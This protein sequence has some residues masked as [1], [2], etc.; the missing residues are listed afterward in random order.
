MGIYVPEKIQYEMIGGM[1]E[2]VRTFRR[3]SKT[4][5]NKIQTQPQPKPFLIP[6]IEP[7]R[8]V[9]TTLVVDGCKIEAYKFNENKTVWVYVDK[10]PSDYKKKLIGMRVGETYSLLGKTYHIDKV[11]IKA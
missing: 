5:P 6:E 7:D 2:L 8:Y 11:F 3:I 10:L 4:Y 1:S 9:E